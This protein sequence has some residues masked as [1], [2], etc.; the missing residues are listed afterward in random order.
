LLG[1]VDGKDGVGRRAGKDGLVFEL[2][3]GEE[4]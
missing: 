1:L 4:L 2:T 3:L